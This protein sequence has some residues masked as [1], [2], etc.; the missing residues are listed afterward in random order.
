MQFTLKIFC[1]LL[2]FTLS[3][4]IA[5]AQTMGKAGGNTLNF[6]DT[7][8]NGGQIGHLQS[9]AFGTFTSNSRWIAIG[10]P[11]GVS[12][13]LYGMRLQD[14]AY[15][16][17]FSYNGPQTNKDLEIVYGTQPILS[18][19]EEPFYQA[20][21]LN[22][23][24]TTDGFTSALR[25]K[26][27][28]SGTL[29]INSTYAGT[30]YKLFVVGTAF[31]SGG[32]LTLS[33]ARYKKGVTAIPNASEKLAQLEGVSYDFKK[34]VVNGIDLSKQ[35][36]K[37]QLGLIAQ[38]LQK[39]FPELVESD[40]SGYLAVN[41]QGLIPVLIEGFNDQQEIINDQ[42]ELITEQ[43]GTISAL[44]VKV[45]N[46]ES[47]LAEIISVLTEMNNDV[48][49]N[50]IQASKK[51]DQIELDQNRPNPFRGMTTIEYKLPLKANNPSLI[52]YNMEGKQIKTIALTDRSGNVNFDGSNLTSGTYVYTLN[53]NGEQLAQQTMVIQ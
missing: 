35:S 7:N 29:S 24:T 23:K 18:S 15:N 32:W 26:L 49:L 43:E 47:Q 53:A 22:F 52:I 5:T 37:K 12:Q 42:G 40:E 10:Q 50:L 30:F 46:L 21:D 48:E 38:D 17:T 41:Y 9:G 6:F 16:G 1:L 31:S 19:S 25:M 2:I 11:S 45:E 51:A 39:V 33:D 3:N 44:N 36:D 28:S 4:E 8:P 20:P 14:R 27:S 13:E 34:D